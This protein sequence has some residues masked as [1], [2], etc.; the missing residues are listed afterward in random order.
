[1]YDADK[2]YAAQLRHCEEI[3]APCFCPGSYNNYR[4]HRCGQNI[5][6]ATGHP[7]AARLP[8]GKVRL[9]YSESVPGISVE[10]AGKELICGCPFCCASYDD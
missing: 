6:S 8:R 10:K 4:C 5:F 3:N 1:M 7:V 9:D 2:A